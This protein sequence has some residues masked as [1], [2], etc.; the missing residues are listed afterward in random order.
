MESGQYGQESDDDDSGHH[1]FEDCELNPVDNRITSIEEFEYEM[2]DISDYEINDL[3]NNINETKV[4]EIN[5]VK[6]CEYKKSNKKS[7][8]K[9]VIDFRK[10]RRLLSNKIFDK[11]REKLSVIRKKGEIEVQVNKTRL[12][13]TNNDGINENDVNIDWA[14]EVNEEMDSNLN[15]KTYEEE[16]FYYDE[17]NE[18]PF[19]IYAESKDKNLGRLHPMALGRILHTKVSSVSNK[20]SNVAAIGINKIKI[21]FND[22]KSANTVVK[23]KLLDEY[24]IKTYI[25]KHKTTRIGIIFNVDPEI[26]EDEIMSCI[27]T[28]VEIIKVKC[29][30]NKKAYNSSY[31]TQRVKIWFRG[32]YLPEN[33]FI[34]SVACEVQ[35]FIENV[36]Q[37]HKCWR[38]GH[39]RLQCQG[40]Q[41]CRKCS[42]EHDVKECVSQI[43]ICALCRNNHQAN[44][45]NCQT[46]LYNKKL[47]ELKAYQNISISEA[48][49][50]LRKRT[51]ADIVQT[52]F[53]NRD[54]QNVFPSLIKQS[55]NQ[56]NRFNNNKF[57]MLNHIKEKEVEIN[58]ENILKIRKPKHTTLRIEGRQKRIN[59]EEYKERRKE[60][61]KYNSEENN[62]NKNEDEKEKKK[63]MKQQFKEIFNKIRHRLSYK[64]EINTENIWTALE[65]EIESLCTEKAVM[66]T[67]KIGNVIED[68]GT[69]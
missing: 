60:V 64:T 52:K 4:S 65:E 39:I 5:L 63:K 32:S 44:D 11:N 27:K 8:K 46:Y 2:D 69:E 31:K 28:D 35:P 6:N 20:I 67:N 50:I 59:A 9:G 13:K 53:Y 38:F 7:I 17:R 55:D 10:K 45:R 49:Q 24:N 36:I 33:V 12:E 42:D 25:P 1:D 19:V 61:T 37:C 15:K 57:E 3:D 23:Q 43:E 34:H 18:G 22:W 14:S 51:Y 40:R 47:K 16:F 21:C 41:R 29:I 30:K 62:P 56:L 58:E 48:K 66:E 54:Y 68:T 26:E